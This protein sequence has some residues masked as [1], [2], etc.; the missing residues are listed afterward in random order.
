M[1]ERDFSTIFCKKICKWLIYLSIADFCCF[2]LTIK[3][4]LVLL[5]KKNSELCLYSLKI[6]GHVLLCHSENTFLKIYLKACTWVDVV[7]VYLKKGGGGFNPTFKSTWKWKI[8]AG[9]IKVATIALF[10]FAKWG[11]F[12]CRIKLAPLWSKLLY[13][14]VSFVAKCF[15]IFQNPYYN[16]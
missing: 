9:I 6:C 1:A 8:E 3:S 12:S 5:I 13:T 4:W 16:L 14:I 7:W 15:K 2:K 11:S 10:L